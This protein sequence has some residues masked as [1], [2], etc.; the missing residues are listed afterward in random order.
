MHKIIFLV[1]VHAHKTRLIIKMCAEMRINMKKRTACITG[2]SS[3]IGYEMAKKL[4]ALGY[5][6]ILV[7]RNT[8]ALKKL[9]ASLDTDCEI[10][11]C[12]LSDGKSCIKLGRKLSKRSDIHI[13]INNAGFG[14]IGDF[15]KTSMAKDISMINVNIR[16]MHILTKYM[17]RS[18]KKMNRG[19][20][21]NV[22]SSA[23]LLPGGPYMATYYATKSYVT[24]LTTSLN[25]EL[26][27][28]HS[29]VH[30]CMLCPGPVD[31]N[32]NNTAGVE[33]ALPGISAEYCASYALLQMFKG[34]VTIVPTFTMKAAV[35]AS[36]LAPREFAAA[37]AAKQ[38]MKKRKDTHNR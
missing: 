19:Y 27:A 4:S 8:K 26:K 1:C 30:I 10:Y 36:K 3:G 28:A 11:T 25:G 33:F 34:R 13:F 21:M 24:S 29:N 7:A 22:A 37:I 2:A 5:D 18:F 9:A 16:A 12:D 15:E 31:T 20:I 32:F 23:G 6:L 35:I 14:D 38:Q 17:L